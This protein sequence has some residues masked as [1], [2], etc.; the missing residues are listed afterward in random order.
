[1]CE[2]RAVDRNLGKKLKGVLGRFLCSLGFHA[3]RVTEVTF[4]FGADDS[5]EKV[6]C[7]RCGV[8]TTRRAR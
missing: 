1:L 5:V 4:G 7:K 8:V 2:L 3:F 6:K